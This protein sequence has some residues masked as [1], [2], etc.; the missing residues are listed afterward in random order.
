[1]DVD[2]Y[3]VS[4]K[5]TTKRDN[6]THC[7]NTSQASVVCHHITAQQDSRESIRVGTKLHHNLLPEAISSWKRESLEDSYNEFPVLY[8]PNPR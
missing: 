2:N 4:I 7:H 1:M 5:Y 6:D 8:L 3:M